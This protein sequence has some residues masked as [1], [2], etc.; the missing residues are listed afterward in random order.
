M[1]LTRYTDFCFRVLIHV[2]LK[3]ETLS[4]TREISERYGIS[5]NHLM[6]VVYDLNVR[7]FLETVR[8]KNGGIRLGRPAERINLGDLI[9]ATED[10]MALAECQ[11]DDGEC[12][13]ATA[14]A[15]HNVLNEA[16]RAFLA[17]LDKYTLADLLAPRED[18]ARLLGM[19]LEGA[20]AAHP[21]VL[22]RACR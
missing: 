21:P 10:D 7:G 3:G 18:L 15:L 12:R 9:R 13:I 8:G 6:K 14:C 20:C 5:S 4:T 19:D 11:G 2:G 1:R 17:V 16:L 22:K